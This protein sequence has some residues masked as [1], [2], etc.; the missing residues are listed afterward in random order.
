VRASVRRVLEEVTI[1]DVAAGKVPSH[2][3]ELTAEP[4][5]WERR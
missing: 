1:A 3:S 4:G 5:A 2:V